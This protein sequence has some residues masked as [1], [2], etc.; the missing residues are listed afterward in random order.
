MKFRYMI[1]GKNGLPIYITSLGEV[2]IENMKVNKYS[3][4]QVLAEKD[5]KE[6][7][8]LTNEVY[9]D[10]DIGKIDENNT[11]YDKN[12]VEFLKNNLISPESIYQSLFNK[13]YIGQ[14][15]EIVPGKYHTVK[16]NILEEKLR[17]KRPNNAYE[18]E[19]LNNSKVTLKKVG[20]RVKD[21]RVIPQYLYHDRGE[22]YC[23]RDVILGEFEDF[24]GR[25]HG[26]W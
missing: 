22:G 12:Y 13:S 1:T 3:I 16:D 4:T 25:K 23:K 15:K 19:R 5:G 10:I 18:K 6:A 2:K 26:L 14:G 11:Q 9:G 8:V 7:D 24:I 20:K 21:G 17:S